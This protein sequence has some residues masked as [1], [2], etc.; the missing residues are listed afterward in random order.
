MKTVCTDEL[1]IYPWSLLFLSAI[2]FWSAHDTLVGSGRGLFG[3]TGDLGAAGL[4]LGGLFWLG[5]A[6]RRFRHVRMAKQE[7]RDP[8]VLR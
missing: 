3:I 1:G 5:L 6:I 8:T 2:M 7:G 4:A